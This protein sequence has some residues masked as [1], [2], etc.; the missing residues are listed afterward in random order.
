MR[1]FV[2]SNFDDDISY[3][4]FVTFRKSSTYQNMQVVNLYQKISLL[5]VGFSLY[6][7]RQYS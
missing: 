4:N 1:A 6:K 5:Y 7:E 2:K 3:D